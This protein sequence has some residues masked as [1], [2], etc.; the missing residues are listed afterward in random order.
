MKNLELTQVDDEY[1]A[2]CRMYMEGMSK[3]DVAAHY[4]AILEHTRA[5]YQ[6]L[7]DRVY[8]PTIR[9]QL[10]KI[11]ALEGKKSRKKR[12]KK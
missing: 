4:T 12:N 11:A 7:I 1:E 3:D 10:E 5:H 9:A 6:G 8:R 2:N